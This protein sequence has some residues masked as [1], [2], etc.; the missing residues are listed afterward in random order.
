LL[1]RSTNARNK[2]IATLAVAASIA[3]VGAAIVPQS[4]GAA[5]TQRGP[6][7]SSWREYNPNSKLQIQS[8]GEYT[9]YPRSVTHATGPGGSYDRSGGIETFRLFNN[10]TNRVEVRVQDNY[11]TGLRQFEGELR[12]TAP[13]NDE[14]AM[15][16]FGNDGPG[17]TTLMIRSYSRNSG[18]LRGGGKDLATNVYG[19]W[20]RI[21]V[22]HD[23]TANRYSIYI[24]GE[25]K[26]SANGPDGTHYFKY[27]VYATLR[28]PSAQHQWHNVHFYRK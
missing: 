25:L 14:S 7:G 12:V 24:N 11:T 28:T 20:M 16:I 21:N 1:G 23:A 2:R 27:G 18:T 5:P 6:I 13:T 17:A 10:G 22:I 4:S 26:A 19:K 3:V 8:R 9:N 15:Q